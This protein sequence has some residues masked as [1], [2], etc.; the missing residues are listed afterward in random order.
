MPVWHPAHEAAACSGA[1]GVWQLVQTVWA[2]TSEATSVGF[3]PWHP[4]HPAAL[5]MKSCGAW[6]P[7]HESWP[8]GFGPAGCAW[9]REQLA[10][11]AS[12]GAWPA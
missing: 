11:A 4:M 12:A 2:C 10:I 6:H 7:R 3:G 8:A 5:A 1:C 9:Q